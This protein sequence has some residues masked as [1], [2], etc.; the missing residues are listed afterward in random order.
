M[1]ATDR[2]TQAPLLLFYIIYILFVSSSVNGHLGYFH[3]LA[4]ANNA[5]LNIDVFIYILFYKLFLNLV[6]YSKHL[7][8][9]L[10]F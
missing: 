6:I 7:S 9:S 8:V 5:A 2:A 10:C 1:S 4:I 3:L